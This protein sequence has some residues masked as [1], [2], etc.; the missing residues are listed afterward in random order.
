MHTSSVHSEP[1]SNSLILKNR[2]ISMISSINFKNNVIIQIVVLTNIKLV[3]L[4]A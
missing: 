2:S 4:I 1:G 3:T